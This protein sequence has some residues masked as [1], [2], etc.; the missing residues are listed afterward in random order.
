MSKRFALWP[1]ELTNVHQLP[2]CALANPGEKL[3]LSL[4]K[5]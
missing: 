2:E 4:F 3:C 5:L 1:F